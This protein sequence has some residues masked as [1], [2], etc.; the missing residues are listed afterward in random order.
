MVI[1]SAPHNLFHG[2]REVTAAVTPTHPN[3]HKLFWLVVY[4][5]LWK[6]WRSVGMVILNIYIYRKKQVPNHQPVLFFVPSF[7]LRNKCCP[8]FQ[9]TSS[10]DGPIKFH[11]AFVGGRDQTHHF[12]KRWVLINQWI[13][14]SLILPNRNML[15]TLVGRSSL[16]P[17]WVSGWNA[18]NEWLELWS[19]GRKVGGF[20]KSEH[21]WTG[22]IILGR[23]LVWIKPATGRICFAEMRELTASCDHEPKSEI[24]PVSSTN[25]KD[26]VSTFPAVACDSGPTWGPQRIEPGTLPWLW[27]KNVW[28]CDPWVPRT[29]DIMKDHDIPCCIIIKHSG[30]SQTTSLHPNLLNEEEEQRKS[31]CSCAGTA[32][33]HHGAC[34]LCF[35]HLPRAERMGYLRQAIQTMFGS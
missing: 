14:L 23:L 7:M 3:C 11:Q 16:L 28:E 6:I 2:H 24:P 21:E 4:L 9:D 15:G 5:P 22:I 33:H 8:K 17:N 29:L 13:S 10:P 1:P 34:F 18:L 32:L 26:L 20:K 31:I 25:S 12:N 27:T 30:P 35:L 19:I